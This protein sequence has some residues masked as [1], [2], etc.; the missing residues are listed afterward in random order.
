MIAVC[1][2]LCDLWLIHLAWFEH[3]KLQLKNVVKLDVVAAVS[4]NHVVVTD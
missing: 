3:R 4:C 1:A 2:F